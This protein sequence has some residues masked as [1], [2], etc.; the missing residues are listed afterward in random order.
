MNCAHLTDAELLRHIRERGG[1][2]FPA[3]HELEQRHF[4]A[5]RTF[6]V[7]ATVRTTAADALAYQSWEETLRQHVDGGAGGA[8]RPCALSSVLTTASG[9]A[10][11]NQ[12]TVLNPQ[13]AAWFDAYGPV[14]PGN[15]ATAGFRRPS[16]VACAFAGL[17]H[18][19]QT[20]LWHKAVE[21]DD[22]ALTG[23]LIG[24]GPGEVSVLTGRAQGELYNSYV[25]VLRDG[26]PYEC[27]RYH[28]LV[29]AYADARSIDIAAQLAP[30]LER[31]P[32]CSG[33]VAD[34]GRVKHDCGA[35]LAQA[36]LPWGGLEYAA[37]GT[38]G[39]GVQETFMPAAGM[40]SS[41]APAAL[42]VGGSATGRGRHAAPR[43]AGIGVRA[44][45]RR[46]T[47]LV[48]RGAAVAGVCAVGAAFALTGAFNKGGEPQSKDPA[49]P[50]AEA[51]VKASPASKSPSPSRTKASAKSTSKD[52]SKA[53]SKSARTKSA[54]PKTGTTRASRTSVGNA[55]VEWLFNEVDGDGVT[56]D[57]SDNNK[58]GTLFGASRPTPVKGGGLAFDGQQFVASSGSLVDTSSSFSVS[59]RVKLD[60]TDVSQTVVS[61][62]AS[63]SSGFQLQ[64]DADESQ[65]EMRMPEQ[66]TADAEGDADEAASESG[67]EVGESTHLTG[68]YDD[69]ADEVRLYVDGRLA[70]TSSREEDFESE[71]NFV[72]GRGLSRNEFFQGLDGTVDDVRAFG[73][74]VSSA[75]A[76]VLARKS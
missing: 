76:K 58:D 44:R 6:A 5:V 40:A 64:Y 54:P 25:E 31:C 75:E 51:S 13:L 43:A 4:H 39:S 45:G 23:R 1:S 38:D 68:V 10:R 36:V 41:A 37:R 35:L 2:Y 14:M 24:A 52:A 18:R 47:D 56:P 57:S 12:R 66:D 53:A 72:V 71:G 8:V 3:L 11:G 61:Q 27:H 48:V 19:R 33:A 29:L 74:A 59:A 26:M 30:H 69:A 20:V 55:A 70:G 73:R 50:P 28:Q 7:A 15:T 21:R 62:D 60:R 17:P 34:L 49:K 65:W 9:W 22:S 16:L 42:P 67:A 63:D 32:R 46:R